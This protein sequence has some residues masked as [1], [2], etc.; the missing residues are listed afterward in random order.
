MTY[1]EKIQ[2]L[3]K[4]IDSVYDEAE[5]LRDC[6]TL[7]EKQYWNEIRK[8]FYDASSPLNKLDNRLSPERANMK[9]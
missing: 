7:D 5:Y 3:I 2:E 8:I 6:A 1:R 9:I 4:S